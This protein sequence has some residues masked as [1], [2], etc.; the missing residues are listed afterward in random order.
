MYNE[1]EVMLEEWEEAREII[2][3]MYHAA[4]PMSDKGR[5]LCKALVAMEESIESI[6]E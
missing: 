5:A 4:E 6:K 3:G 1:V 2:E